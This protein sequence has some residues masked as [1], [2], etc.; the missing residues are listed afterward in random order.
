MYY[1]APWPSHSKPGLV[2]RDEQSLC[3]FCTSV[4]G[5][6]LV[7]RRE[8]D[9]G[10]VCKLRRGEARLKIFLPRARVPRTPAGSTP[11]RRPSSGAA[12]DPA[13]DATR[14]G[15]R[16]PI[17]RRAALA[18]RSCSSPSPAGR[19]RSARSEGS[20]SSPGRSAEPR[21]S[22]NAA[23][24]TRRR[25]ASCIAA[26]TSS[27]TSVAGTAKT[28]A[29]TTPGIPADDA[30]DGAGREVLAVDPEPVVVAAREPQPSV[31]VDVA[32]VARPVP[33]VAR[34]LAHRFV[35]LVVTLEQGRRGVH[36]LADAFV[37][38][39]QP[40]GVVEPR[41]ARGFTASPDRRRARLRGGPERTLR[42]VG[43]ARMTVTPP[44]VDP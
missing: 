25:V 22:S 42:L 24:R 1:P 29:S 19:P 38:V 3:D 31:V 34:A 40:A 44:S 39:E 9:V 35:V 15:R 6:L 7:E 32:E 5:F 26:M 41:T 11:R 4:M 2:G 37:G 36:D 43:G 14:P 18:S 28:A 8:F 17:A 10:T 13:R 23:G 27:P 21:N 20:T 16:T 12:A 33:A 30:L